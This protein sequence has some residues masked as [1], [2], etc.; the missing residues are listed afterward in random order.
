M[1][2]KVRL[3]AGD[4]YQLAWAVHR[5]AQMVVDDECGRRGVE[6]VGSEQGAVEGW[7]DVVEQRADGSFVHH[8]VK[9]QMLDFDARPAN[10]ADV[11]RPTPRKG[12][13]T[14]ASD[15]APSPD[16][17]TLD[18]LFVKLA[19]WVKRARAAQLPQRRFELVV[20][21][22]VQIKA[23]L[24]I[25]NLLELCRWCSADGA[26]AARLDA[27]R[28]TTENA[29]GATGD[30]TTIRLFDWLT[31]WCDFEGAEEI[32]FAL[33]RLTVR[34]PG[35]DLDQRT[36][37]LLQPC[38]SEAAAAHRAIRNHLR[39]NASPIAAT[40]PAALDPVLEP[41]RCSPR[42]TEFRQTGLDWHTAGT[43][44][45]GL[46]GAEREKQ[47][48]A[49]LWRPAAQGELRVAALPDRRVVIT[50]Y[51]SRLALHLPPTAQAKLQNPGSWRIWIEGEVGGTLGLDDRE[52][53][54]DG[55]RD[56][57]DAIGTEPCPLTRT[58][59]DSHPLCDE[60][61]KQTWRAVCEE[62]DR[63]R[64]GMS[65][66]WQD[67]TKDTWG[68]WRSTL[69]I[70]S[71][72]HEFLCKLMRPAAEGERVNAALRVGLRTAPLMANALVLLLM[73]HSA[74]GE[75]SSPSPD[76]LRC[77]GAELTVRTLALRQWSGPAGKKGGVWRLDDDPV[78]AELLG[79]ERADVLV[80]SGVEASIPESDFMSGLRD[81]DQAAKAPRPRLVVTS[82]RNVRQTRN[83]NIDDLRRA[84]QSSLEALEAN[85]TDHQ[86]GTEHDD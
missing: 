5:V 2:A 8:Q 56:Y 55:W 6:A 40:T 57:H 83:G 14:S 59:H 81:R 47:V 3:T 36:Q 60:M 21:A 72:R 48:V 39:D 31:T 46:N 58:G 22:S 74:L 85:I 24:T 11:R 78:R 32:F 26:T 41:Y 9:H 75:T 51:L 49:A 16:L 27:L 70:R 53:V 77:F 35:A 34:M 10:R 84:L 30:G 54:P 76:R 45:R 38:Y 67:A 18:A 42:W 15:E 62:V 86:Q 25:A 44:A 7:D 12:A 80:L 1:L 63:L 73:V 23:D 19:R 20:P 29:S 17:S 50:E 82:A 68:H 4:E 64:S 66:D 52:V 13:A 43:H 33:S 71:M 37:E 69:G 28:Q 61:D 79:N 65:Q